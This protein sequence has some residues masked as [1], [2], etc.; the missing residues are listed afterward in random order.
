MRTLRLVNARFWLFLHL[1]G[2]TGTL[3][4]QRVDNLPIAY[5]PLDPPLYVS[6]TFGELR[7]NHFHAGIDLRTNEEIGK[8]VYAVNDGFVSRVKVSPVG[9]GLAVYLDHP[10]GFTS[11]YGHLDRYD[12]PLRSW[13]EEAQK[14]SGFWELDTLLPPGL[15]PVLGGERIA[16]SGNSGG[17]AG[18]HV[19]FEWRET[20]TEHPVN[21]LFYGLK[22]VDEL[23]PELRE[24]YFQDAGGTRKTNVVRDSLGHR[25]R[26]TVLFQSPLGV[27]LDA[28]DLM[29]PNGPRNGV[30]A[31]H[32]ECTPGYRF[33]YTFDSFDFSDGRAVNATQDPTLFAQTGKRM[34]RVYR[35]PFH[36]G[37][38]FHPHSFAWSYSEVPVNTMGGRIVAE[39]GA[40]VRA[41]W[42][43]W[44]ASGKKD[45]VW[46]YLKCVESQPFS[47]AAGPSK[48]SLYS[49]GWALVASDQSFYRKTTVQWS[50]GTAESAAKAS[51]T[52]PAH[53]PLKL[54][55]PAS[56]LSRSKPGTFF[57]WTAASGKKAWMSPPAVGTP[58]EIK[59]PGSGRWQQD[60]TPPHFKKP[61]WPTNLTGGKVLRFTGGDAESGM[62]HYGAY[63]EDGTYV[64]LAYDAKYKSFSV[65][66]PTNLAP[67]KH[68]LEVVLKD[69]AGNVARFFH[70]FHNPSSSPGK[71]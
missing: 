18:P 53:A 41:V 16:T 8:P 21:P 54:Y 61:P 9:Y 13:V 5:P 38:T 33:G 57:V 1:V 10:S 24:V 51:W 60:P 28:E 4:S 20:L 64:L 66:L 43:V 11:V 12:G 40:V 63:L 26:D 67:G 2:F 34:Y 47:P 6:G 23:P 69:R 27:V 68:T 31:V 49:N 3:F 56:E 30:Y 32:Q 25:L 42:R 29:Q 45:S 58:L 70:A 65:Q 55:P 35:Q 62:A 19:H 59:E 52:G 71:T 44:D 39:P 17:S 15:L 14:K 22:V 37:P 7:N 36:P 50:G 48:D 46:G